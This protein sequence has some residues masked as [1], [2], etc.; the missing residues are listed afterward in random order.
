MWWHTG[1]VL[2]IVP[3]WK[4]GGG[5]GDGTEGVETEINEGDGIAVLMWHWG[6]SKVENLDIIDS[7]AGRSGIP[8]GT[9][10]NVRG[11]SEMTSE[12]FLEGPAG[13]GT[14]ISPYHH[15]KYQTFMFLI[16]PPALP[17]CLSSI[18]QSLSVSRS[19]FVCMCVRACAPFN[20][21]ILQ[22]LS[23]SVR[24]CVCIWVCFL[25]FWPYEA[26]QADAI[27]FFVVVVLLPTSSCATSRLA[28]V[29]Y[30]C[31]FRYCDVIADCGYI[32]NKNSRIERTVKHDSSALWIYRGSTQEAL[33]PCFSYSIS[34]TQAHPTE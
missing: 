15:H 12:N 14:R 19:L 8:I 5:T 21:W 4:G 33:Q 32:W 24:I 31:T 11:C 17:L 23:H 22:H 16:I 25:L 3:V 1:I 13:S 6:P 9:Q 20:L 7:Y 28:A 29:M 26:T 10:R 2:A 30:R 18:M 27:L 34:N